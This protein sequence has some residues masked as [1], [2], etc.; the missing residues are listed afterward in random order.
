MPSKTF[1]EYFNRFGEKED[2]NKK[3]K[4]KIFKNCGNT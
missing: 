2:F 1:F 3:E 4:T